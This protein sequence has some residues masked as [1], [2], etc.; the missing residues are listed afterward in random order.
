[1]TLSDFINARIGKQVDFDG[2]YGY[3]CVDLVEFYNH[4]VVGAPALG[5]NAVDL[6]RNPQPNF[7]SYNANT[8]FYIPPA[9]AIAIWNTN[10]G[11]GYGHCA[12][13][14]NA[15]LM[16]FVSLDQN[17]PKGAPVSKVTHNYQNVIGFLVPRVSNPAERYN[18]LVNDLRTLVGN[19]QLA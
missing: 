7:Y 8:P 5:G 16:S 18:S 13:V 10:L 12:I 19:Y 2:Q 15:S 6:A 9:G 1:M 4:D 17:W 11:D 3:Q 14:L